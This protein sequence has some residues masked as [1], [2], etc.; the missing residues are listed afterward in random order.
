MNGQAVYVVNCN[1]VPDQLPF[2][3][4]SRMGS[5]FRDISEL[6]PERKARF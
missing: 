1:K 4:P 2:G 5:K 3:T 6:V